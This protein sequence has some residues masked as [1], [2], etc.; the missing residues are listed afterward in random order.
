MG[1]AFYGDLWHGAT[2]PNQDI[3]GLKV[4]TMDYCDIMD[5]YFSPKVYHWDDGAH[6][7]YLSLAA[8]QKVNQLF[9]SY[10]DEKL[11]KEKVNYVRT[12]GLGGLIIWQLAGDYRPALSP[13]KRDPLLSAI[14]EALKGPMAP[15]R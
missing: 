8:D 3:T 9:I 4:E 13:G 2:G 12:Y 11:C 7:P 10:D 6:S 15:V 14:G 5:K 1:V